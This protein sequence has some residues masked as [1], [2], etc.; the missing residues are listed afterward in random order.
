M[1]PQTL[2]QQVQEIVELSDDPRHL[3]AKNLAD[4]QKERLTATY[5]R[6]LGKYAYEAI[7]ESGLSDRLACLV[8]SL[9]EE[10]DYQERKEIEKEIIE[11]VT[12]HVIDYAS[13]PIDECIDDELT[14]L[15]SLRQFPS[16]TNEI[17]ANDNAQRAR[18]MKLAARGY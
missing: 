10:T 1:K 12:E 4:C 13:K 17:I 14:F 2:A 5:L 3:N 18:D 8:I 15:Q 6:Q 16:H 11:A 7:S 9:F